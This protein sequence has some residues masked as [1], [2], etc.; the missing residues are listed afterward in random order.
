[1][2]GRCFLGMLAAAGFTGVALASPLTGDATSPDGSRDE[3][4]Q[5][6]RAAR[7]PPHSDV[8]LSLRDQ[9]R[10]TLERSDDTG[11][12]FEPL[13]DAFFADDPNRSLQSK[14]YGHVVCG[15]SIGWRN[16]LRASFLR[17]PELTPDGL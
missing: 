15:G 8:G 2:R 9:A 7:T 14:V 13:G 4:T 5:L 6:Q 3:P 16:S 17:L 1:M 10:A 12:R 11:C